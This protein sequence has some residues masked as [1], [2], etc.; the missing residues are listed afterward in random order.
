[1][2]LLFAHGWGFD[3]SFWE[4]LAALLPEHAHVFDDRGYFGRPAPTEIAGPC[5]AI[6]HSF[7]TMRVLT[8]PPPGLVGIVAFNGFDRFSARSGRAG[9]PVRVIDRMLR[10][11]TQ[12]PETV[13]AEFRATCGDETQVPTPVPDPL[14]EDLLRLRDGECPPPAVPLTSVQG[15]ADPLLVREIRESVFPRGEV[16]RVSHTGGHLLPVEDPAFCAETVRAMVG[17]QVA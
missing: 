17:A 2:N 8:N 12:S 14:R 11:F 3:A 1:M 5:L 4:P 10:R 6:T 16:R 9:I 13:L 7:G 15:G